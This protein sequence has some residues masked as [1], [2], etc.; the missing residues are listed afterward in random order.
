MFQCALPGKADTAKAYLI[1]EGSWK[2]ADQ[3][4][5]IFRANKKGTHVHRKELWD[6]KEHFVGKWMKVEFESWS[7]LG[8][9]LKP[10][11]VVFREVDENGQPIE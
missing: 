6:N 10:I 3:K 11:G 7:K 4:A 2:K 5:G 1:G 8:V 9:P